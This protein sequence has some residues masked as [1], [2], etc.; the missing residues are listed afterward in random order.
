M[1]EFLYRVQPTRTNMLANGPTP[2]EEE[3]VGRH[4]AY[5]QGLAEK[6]VVKL[7]GR[8]LTTNECAFGIVIF[9]ADTL[10]QAQQLV[11]DDPA[12]KE[13]VMKAELFPFRVAL[14]GF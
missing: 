3:V 9:H 7:A 4:F 2:A 11:A 8:T 1:A 10:K 5:L 13:G 12:V 6:G 14:N